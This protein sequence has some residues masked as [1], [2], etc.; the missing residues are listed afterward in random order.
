MRHLASCTLRLL[1]VICYLSE[2]NS[3]EQI[4]YF[5][6]E[7]DRTAQQRPRRADRVLYDNQDF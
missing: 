1:F 7:D 4:I 5:V 6:R 3:R 2:N